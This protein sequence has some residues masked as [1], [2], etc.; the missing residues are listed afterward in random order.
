[1]KGEIVGEKEV[2]DEA[3]S[4]TDKCGGD[5]LYTYCIDEYYIYAILYQ[6]G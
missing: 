6:G 2:E 3:D 4:V 1:V 5:S